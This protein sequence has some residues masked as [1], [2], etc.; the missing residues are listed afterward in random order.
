METKV[1]KIVL[2]CAVLGLI[3]VPCLQAAIDW[4]IYESLSISEGDY[5]SVRVY[6]SQIEPFEQ[7]VVNLLN[8]SISRLSCFDNSIVNMYGGL[9]NTSVGADDNSTLNL[10]GGDIVE[11]WVTENATLNIY[12][13]GF[14]TE[15][16]G[17]GAHTL[18]TG[19]W[20]DGS[21]FSIMFRRSNT[22]PE[23]VNLLPEPATLLLLCVGGLVLRKRK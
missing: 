9:I 22:L 12:G 17:S 21:E 23:Q 13:Y 20:L 7:T 1:K 6:Q 3:F 8:G 15:L 11:A 18:L 19:F 16:I 14:Q 5:Y 2:V 4:D 10:Y